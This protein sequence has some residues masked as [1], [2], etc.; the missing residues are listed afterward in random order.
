M[1]LVQADIDGIEKKLKAWK[2]KRELLFQTMGVS[3]QENAGTAECPGIL[4]EN[5]R[6]I[7]VDS[8]DSPYSAQE[9]I[10]IRE[11]LKAC[12]ARS[13]EPSEMLAAVVSVSDLPGT[14]IDPIAGLRGDHTLRVGE[15]WRI[16]DGEDLW[17][18]RL[19]RIATRRHGFLWNR[20]SPSQAYFEMRGAPGNRRLEQEIPLKGSFH[21]KAGRN[22]IPAEYLGGSSSRISVRIS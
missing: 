19:M 13:A 15:G 7:I 11:L 22:E 20:E 3:L 2:S 18:I 16:F 4:A 21:L 8:P 14:A 6:R 17:Q 12:Q 9:R 5:L 1:E 10:Q